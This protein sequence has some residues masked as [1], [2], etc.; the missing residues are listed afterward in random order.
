[1][2]DEKPLNRR[3]FFRSSLKQLLGPVVQSVEE[4]VEEISRHFERDES[5]RHALP[6]RPPGALKED[7]FLSTCSRCG[8]CVEVCPAHCIK[9]EA[10]VHAGAPFIE[11]GEMPC[12]LC[13]ELACMMSCPSGALVPT[14][15]FEIEMGLAEWDASTCKRTSGEDCTICVDEC[16]I[17]QKAISLDGARVVVHETGCTGC[18]VC[19]HHCPTRPRS[20]VVKPKR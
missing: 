11:P 1:M 5:R 14:R 17:G 3:S 4:R 10:G 8:K 19:Q 7:D 20:I 6:L 2:S 12:V 15:L 13:S 9:M 18:G 16:P